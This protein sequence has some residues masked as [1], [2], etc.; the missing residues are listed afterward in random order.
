MAPA[1]ACRHG[2]VLRSGFADK[3]E[4][5]TSSC[6]RC[7]KSIHKTETLYSCQ[8]CAIDFCAA[9]APFSLPSR[10]ADGSHFALS[11]AL[12]PVDQETR[13]AT[14]LDVER[15]TRSATPLSILRGARTATPLA[16]ERGTRTA[17]PLLVERATR[18]GTPLFVERGTRTG[19]PVASG[20]DRPGHASSE[21]ESRT[22]LREPLLPGQEPD[23]VARGLSV[24]DRTGLPFEPLRGGFPLRRGVVAKQGILQGSRSWGPRRRKSRV[25]L[26][27]EV[28]W[29]TFQEGRSE[30]ITVSLR[31]LKEE[32]H[33]GFW[34]WWAGASH[35]GVKGVERPAG[36]LESPG[37]PDLPSPEQ[38]PLSAS[39][40]PL[41]PGSLFMR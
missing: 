36:S 38:S 32:S 23:G 10:Q 41:K 39:L 21:I 4:N 3:P 29:A 27:S 16:V 15:G 19:T 18:T 33:G 34:G 17:T 30:E 14:P 26:R 9:C 31:G 12:R 25:Q 8:N 6:A 1:S 13:S 22:K 37:V 20:Q 11:S 5:E 40:V 7:H 2:H 35:E 24:S 28:E